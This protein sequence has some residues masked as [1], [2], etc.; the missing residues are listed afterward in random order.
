MV[1]TIEAKRAEFSLKVAIPQVL[2]YMLGKPATTQPMYGL[3]TNGS[4]FK[5]L[6]LQVN[7]IPQYQVSYTLSLDRGD[8]LQRVVRI[9]KR[10]A[11]GVIEA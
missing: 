11:S 4:E 1:I 3:V 5:F 10:L 7:D 9:L 6:K 2:F 8:D